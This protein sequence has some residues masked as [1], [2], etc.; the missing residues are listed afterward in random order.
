MSIY[1]ARTATPD[2]TPIAHEPMNVPDA[3]GNPSIRVSVRAGGVPVADHATSILTSTP[4]RLCVYAP[5]RR[6]YV[7][8]PA[9]VVPTTDG[10][11]LH[12]PVTPSID[13]LGQP[14][15]AV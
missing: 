13:S 1:P 11:K 10:V 8:T 6:V 4:A 12:G 7:N 15:A 14:V 5:F 9:V 3:T 2:T